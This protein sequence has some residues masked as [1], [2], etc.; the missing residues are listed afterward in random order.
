MAADPALAAAVTG[1]RNELAAIS[2]RLAQV[3]QNQRTAQLGSSSV[4]NGAIT[5]NDAAG[6]PQVVLGL[7]P[8]GTFAHASVTSQ[9]PVA[10]D[11][12]LTA[13]GILGA[14][15][16]WDGGMSDGSSPLADFAGVQV[17]L[18]TVNGF[19]PTA[20][21]LQGGMPGPGSFGV[22]G[23]VAGTVYYTAL[24]AYNVAGNTSPP[25]AQT[26]VTPQSVP[27][28]IPPGAIS[29]LQIQ[30]GAVTTAQIAANAGILGE[31]IAGQTITG[32][33]IA[34]NSISA[35][36]LTAGII[37]AG[38]IDGTEVS[39]PVINGG[40]IN[41][42]MI[43]A[44]NIN[45][46][47]INATT[48]TGD[49]FIIN[50]SGAFF[51]DGTPGPG[52]L[53]VA[54]SPSAGTDPF[55]TSVYQGITIES[56]ALSFPWSGGVNQ[57][58]E[59]GNGTLA[60][61]ESASGNTYTLGIWVVRLAS[62]VTISSGPTVIL[63]VNVAA[64]TYHIRIFVPYKAAAGTAS[65]SPSIGWD[66]TSITG[67]TVGQLY[68]GESGAGGSG[69]D[70]AGIFSQV[71]TVSGGAP[72]E[73]GPPLVTNGVWAYEFEGLVTFTTAGTF[74]VRGQTSGSTYTVPINAYMEIMPIS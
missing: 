37:I 11:A 35:N 64:L 67:N 19:T 14:T 40:I 9:T 68:F 41:G 70:Y 10:P 49:D 44:T 47:V 50:D 73:P 5:F 30:T 55:G 69:N 12:P 57:I 72:L 22:G 20:A 36:L 56:G 25:S 18:S 45:G 16:A 27:A 39:A 51:Y 71:I 21:S 66:G 38:V 63:Q 6:A 28:N 2:A 60:Y 29:G 13:P 26:A 54:M 32:A 8:D 59:T 15:V 33:N 61:T 74:S 1:L 53:I 52:D 62:P 7:Q 31:Q 24:V 43:N 3:E 65:G 58:V 46:G 4:E 48:F 34:A 42:V 23:L 17:H